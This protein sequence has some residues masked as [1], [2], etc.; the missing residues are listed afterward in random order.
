MLKNWPNEK[1][2][3]WPPVERKQQVGECWVCVI[4]FPRLVPRAVRCAGRSRGVT[5]GAAAPPVGV[6][7]SAPKIFFV[8]GADP[9]M[10]LCM[11]LHMVLGYDGFRPLVFCRFGQGNYGYVLIQG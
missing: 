7:G 5:G 8:W 4:F 11:A 2:L 10:V 6:R 1:A 3:L 9:P